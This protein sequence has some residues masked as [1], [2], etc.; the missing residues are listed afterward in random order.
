MY[1]LNL[2]NNILQ[3]SKSKFCIECMPKKGIYH[4]WNNESIAETPSKFSTS[5]HFGLLCNHNVTC[6]N[7]HTWTHCFTS[8][9]FGIT[10]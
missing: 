2:H 10:M 9:H 6:K 8:G 4:W 7:F 5:G 3:D 1:A